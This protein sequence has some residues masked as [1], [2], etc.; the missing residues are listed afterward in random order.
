M[1][2]RWKIVAVA[3]VLLVAC[4]GDARNPR[5]AVA[6]RVV[7]TPLTQGAAA[8][9]YAAQSLAGDS[10]AFG[11]GT[12]A[13]TLVNVWA[14]WCTSCRE[15]FA[16]LERMR[17]V[18][19]TAG[20]RIVAVSVDQGGDD[21]VRRFAEAQGAHFPVVHDR[22]ARITPLYGVV[23]LPTTYLIGRDGHIAWMLTGSFLESREALERAILAELKS[24]PNGTR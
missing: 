18:H 10:V 11:I 2:P 3:G 9:A 7:P 24:A 16:E 12:S 21:K 5:P 15:E 8:P 6:S 23:G 4:R 22:D 1:R 19:G 14:L 17:N 20:L 13:P